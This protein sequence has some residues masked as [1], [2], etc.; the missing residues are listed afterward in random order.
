MKLL[1]S[2]MVLTVLLMACSRDYN[3]Y[4]YG[5]ENFRS[6]PCSW[7]QHMVAE[8]V[9][10]SL[11]IWSLGDECNFGYSA[12]HNV[13]IP[14]RKGSYGTIDIVSISDTE[15]KA[16][17]YVNQED[18]FTL[19]RQTSV[20]KPFWVINILQ[21]IEIDRQL[22]EYIDQSTN[23]G[24]NSDHLNAAGGP[25]ERVEELDPREFYNYYRNKRLIEA[26]RAIKEI[27]R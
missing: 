26:E 18:K 22:E 16:V 15:I 17:I 19:H 5:K 23:D 9:G 11:Q 7:N 1:A 12:T 4:Y 25:D 24:P 3:N 27:N 20:Q 6:F 21:S 14:K 10:D 8:D 2:V 13:R